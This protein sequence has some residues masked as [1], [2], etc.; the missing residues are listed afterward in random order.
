MQFIYASVVNMSD[1]RLALKF[2]TF[3]VLSWCLINFVGVF[4]KNR[5]KFIVGGQNFSACECKFAWVVDAD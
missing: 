4:L 1:L 3:V 2:A 5:D